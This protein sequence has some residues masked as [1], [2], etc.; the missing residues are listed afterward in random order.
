MSFIIVSQHWVGSIDLSVL[1]VMTWV[2]RWRATPDPGADQGSERR[3][4]P[5]ANNPFIMQHQP[6]RTQTTKEHNLAL[7]ESAGARHRPLLEIIFH[8]ED[9]HLFEGLTPETETL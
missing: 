5:D 8:L 6:A 1:L 7:E 3:V 9:Q 2:R 4:R